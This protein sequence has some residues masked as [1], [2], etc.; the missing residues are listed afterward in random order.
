MKKI[1]LTIF[2]IFFILNQSFSQNIEDRSIQSDCFQH[3]KNQTDQ[4]VSNLMV[5]SGLFFLGTPYVSHTLEVN[6]KESLVINLREMDCTTFIE[7]CLA[8]TIIA[9]KKTPDNFAATLQ[10]IR[11]R[12]G[13]I[14]GY[15]SRLH[16][17]SDW[18]YDNQ[19]KGFVKD[20]T[21]SIGGKVLPL[22]LDFMSTHPQSYKQ[23]AN[24]PENVNQIKTIEDSINLRSHYYIPKNEI[25]RIKGQIQNGDIIAF[26]TSI[27]GLDISHVAI[28]YWKDKQLTFI[29]ASS[30]FKQVIVNPKPLAEYCNQQTKNLGI[31]VIRPI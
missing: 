29:H 15:T 21:Q 8:F 2:S 5:Q 14:D 7:N 18:I 26:V 16:Y 27:R 31:M 25:P 13:K 9:R 23:L 12:H 3:L 24:S 30:D 1:I 19:Q 28:A 6:D 17:T 4:S 10:S 20:I 22:K 11:Y